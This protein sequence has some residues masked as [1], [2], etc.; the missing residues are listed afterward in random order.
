[1]PVLLADGWSKKRLV[2]T[3]K[4]LWTKTNPHSNGYWRICTHEG[5]SKTIVY[6]S[7][8]TGFKIKGAVNQ[9]NSGK[10]LNGAAS[11]PWYS[12]RG[13]AAALHW[14]H[15]ILCSIWNTGIIPLDSRRSDVVSICTE[16]CDAQ[17]YNNYENVSL[18][19]VP[20]KVLARILPDK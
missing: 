19:F 1:M 13:E 3:M 10:L 14:L 5:L 20:G 18:L 8:H 11:E 12:R 6:G 2:E 7:L 15:T 4:I 9:L 17:E 16:N